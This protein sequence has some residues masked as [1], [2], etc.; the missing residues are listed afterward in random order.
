MEL[1]LNPESTVD[2]RE[3]ERE[4]E[5]IRR[6]VRGFLLCSVTLAVSTGGFAADSGGGGRFPPGPSGRP[7]AAASAK[8]D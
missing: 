6:E 1:I 8:P 3:R 4:R 5:H 2:P 7:A